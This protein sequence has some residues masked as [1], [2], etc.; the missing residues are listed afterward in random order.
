MT[1]PERIYVC[2][3]G[4]CRKAKRGRLQR[5]LDDLGVEVTTVKCQRLCDGPVVGCDVD[6]RLEWFERVR[7]RTAV[8]AFAVLVR[9]GQVPHPLRKRRSKKRSGRLRA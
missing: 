3:G 6:G 2:R 9:T 1:T 5:A 8:A 7:G 4:D